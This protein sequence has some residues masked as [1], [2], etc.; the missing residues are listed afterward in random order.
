MDTD[1]LTR[2]LERVEAG[3]TTV[4]DADA[5]R[6]LFGAQFT[7]IPRPPPDDVPRTDLAATRRR[8][9]ARAT[10]RVGL[11][12]DRSPQGEF[13]IHTSYRRPDGAITAD[14]ARRVRLTEQ[15]GPVTRELWEVLFD[16]AALALQNEPDACILRLNTTGLDP[17]WARALRT[18]GEIV[19]CELRIVLAGTA[20]IREEPP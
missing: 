18:V 17:G 1:T 11:V 14:R 15:I 10:V 19:A 13:R 16:A 7:P 5:L 6:A 20:P 2:I 8:T 3:T 9:G 4:T 12:R